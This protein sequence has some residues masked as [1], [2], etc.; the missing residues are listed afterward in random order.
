VKRRTISKSPNNNLI[1]TPDG[2]N[3]YVARGDEFE[4]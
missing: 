2:T 1:Y 3:V 4:L